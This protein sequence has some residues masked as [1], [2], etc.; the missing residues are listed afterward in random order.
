MAVMA[1]SSRGS[2]REA[3][4]NPG[5][6][7]SGVG[8]RALVCKV[9]LRLTGSAYS[10]VVGDGAVIC[11]A[12]GGQCRVCARPA[13]PPLGGGGVGAT[14]EEP[15]VNSAQA[16]GQQDRLRPARAIETKALDRCLDPL[17]G[18]CNKGPSPGDR[19]E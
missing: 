5:P 2:R 16:R 10:P 8:S 1:P 15:R 19:G 14:G 11:V 4:E 9:A 6:S 17:G 12:D 18:E 13:R 7:V 3:N